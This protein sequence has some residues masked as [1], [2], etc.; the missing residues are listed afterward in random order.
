MAPPERSRRGCGGCGVDDVRHDVDV[1]VRGFGIRALH[2]RS[3]HEPLRG[4][5]VYTGQ[6]DIQAGLNEVPAVGSAQVNFGVNGRFVASGR[7]GKSDN[8]TWGRRNCE[9]N[10]LHLRLMLGADAYGLWEKKSAKMGAELA[11]WRKKGEATAHDGAEVTP[12]GG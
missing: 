12:I 6:A 3:V 11:A 2:V 9:Q 8:K 5:A 10:L 1:A 4:F 7:S